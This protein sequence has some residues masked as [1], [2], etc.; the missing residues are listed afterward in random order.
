VQ[1]TDNDRDMLGGG[2]GPAVKTSMELVMAIG[3]AAG[4]HRLIDISAAHVDGSL[5]HG[6]ATLE[7]AERLAG[8]EGQVRVP[9]TLNVTALDLL[10]PE[11]YRGDEEVA[12]QQRKQ[13]VAYLAMGCQPTWTCAPYQLPD[14]P[15]FGDQVAWGES[16][17]IVY[18]NSVIGA[19]T[20]RYGDFLDICCALTGRAPYVGLHTDEG[21][22]ATL[23][24]ELEVPDEWL[25]ND[26]VYPV[27]GHL[28][29]E[30]AGDDVPVIIG[31]DHRASTDRLKALG[32]AA[33]SSGAVGMFH[34]VGVTPEAPDLETSLQ[35]MTPDRVFSLDEGSLR[36]G[37]AE[38][39][40]AHSRLGAVCLGTPHASMAELHSLVELARGRESRV[41]FYVNT[42]R[43]IYQE[44][45]ESG[46]ASELEAFGA[47]VVVDTCTYITPILEPVDGAVMTNSGKWAY[48]APANLGVDVILGT[49][50]DCVESAVTGEIVIG[51]PW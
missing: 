2:L 43:H 50:A 37:L 42:A 41:P 40:S 9:T 48:Y 22:R 19:R 14:P 51:G 16:N 12:A 1:L 18:A 31:L 39:S 26:L 32:A 7:F 25:D 15:Q 44:A 8:D 6:L 38:L 23:V 20:N 45:Q 36:E 21:R 4:A 27:L 11:L 13:I 3:E 47:I 24:I 29:G 34:A 33:A 35:G 10:H 46:L 17:A 5:Y 28:V 49:Q 30:L